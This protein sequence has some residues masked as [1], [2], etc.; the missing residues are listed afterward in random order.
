[1]L[2]SAATP[3]EL[4]EWFHREDHGQRVLCLVLA[5]SARDQAKLVTTIEEVCLVDSTIGEDI[6]LLLADPRADYRLGFHEEHWK[7]A[8]LPA[9]SFTPVSPHQKPVLRLRFASGLTKGSKQAQRRRAIFAQDLALHSARFVPDLLVHFKISPSELPCLFLLVRGIA[10]PAIVSLG[11][12]WSTDSLLTL[13]NQIR[14]TADSVPDFNHELARLAGDIPAALPRAEDLV[15]RLERLTSHLAAK[16]EP[17]LVRHG[18]T[19]ADRI[20]MAELIAN[21]LDS[22]DA[23]ET[24]LGKL[25]FAHEEAFLRDRRMVAVRALLNRV[26]STRASLRNLDSTYGVA[27]PSLLDRATRITESR[28]RLLRLLQELRPARLSE[29]STIL[30]DRATRVQ[31]WLEQINLF[32]DLSEKSAALIGIL[33]RLSGL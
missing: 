29:T 30:P 22:A 28:E 31:R 16:L 5:P 15:R 19:E 4:A 24:T 10:S 18:A 11:K 9:R 1:M 12:D 23:F 13:L 8:T 2:V 33:R 26:L 6:A 25:S 27:I 14:A 32:G 3:R 20:Q 21:G 17:I 7:L